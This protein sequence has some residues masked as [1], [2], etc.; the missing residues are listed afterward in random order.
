MYYDKKNLL[1]SKRKLRMSLFTIRLETN[2]LNMIAMNDIV[3]I[4]KRD[5]FLHI[6]KTK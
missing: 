2:T 1:Q 3:T 5:I 4:S 6:N